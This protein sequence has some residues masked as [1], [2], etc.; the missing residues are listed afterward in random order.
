MHHHDHRLQFLN[1]SLE[2][3]LD[4]GSQRAEGDET[5]DGQLAV[6]FLDDQLVPL[7]SHHVFPLK[8]FSKI[9]VSTALKHIMPQESMHHPCLREQDPRNQLVLYK[10]LPQGWV[11]FLSS[12]SQ[13]VLSIY[14]VF[15]PGDIPTQTPLPKS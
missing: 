2:L 13:P 12:F 9:S 5:P 1:N 14:D 6:K 4:T 10:P 8:C 3:V 7:K 15:T 11:R